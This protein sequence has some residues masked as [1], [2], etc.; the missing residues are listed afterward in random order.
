MAKLV[1]CR[2]L[3]LIEMLGQI[4]VVNAPAAAVSAWALMSHILDPETA[5]KVQIAGPKESA[6]LLRR[7]IDD[8]NIPAFLGGTKY[9]N[10]DPECR[11]LL[12]PGGLPPEAALSR[13]TDLVA[14]GDHCRPRHDSQM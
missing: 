11:L 14:K 13:L 1:E 2:K 6:D 8:S 4:L 5:S 7:Y 10:G 12:A 3:L 9:V